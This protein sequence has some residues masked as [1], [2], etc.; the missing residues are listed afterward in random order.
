MTKSVNTGSER[1]AAAMARKAN[2]ASRVFDEKP[3]RKLPLMNRPSG[4]FS[5]RNRWKPPSVSFAVPI[6]LRRASQ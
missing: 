3:D 4:A 5:S 2:S 6:T 1:I